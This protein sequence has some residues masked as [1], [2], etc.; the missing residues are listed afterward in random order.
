MAISLLAQ[1]VAYCLF[2]RVSHANSSI[3]ICHLSDFG[4]YTSPNAKSCLFQGSIVFQITEK[5]FICFQINLIWIK[6]SKAN[7]LTCM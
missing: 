4:A 7:T 5:I 6:K 2:G 3:D 1:K